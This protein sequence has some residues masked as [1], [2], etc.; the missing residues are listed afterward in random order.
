VSWPETWLRLR[1]RCLASE[2]FQ[3]WASRSALT[4][5]IARRRAGRLFDLC[6]GF[7]YSQIL[8]ASVETG[9]LEALR[10]GPLSTAELDRKLDL[11]PGRA[12]RLIDGSLALDLLQSRSGGRIGLGS[13][14]ATL[15]GNPAVLAMVRHHRLLYADLADPVALLR[16][17]MPCTALQDYWAYAQHEA[18]LQLEATRTDDYSAL[19]AASQ[20]LIATQVLDAYPLHRHRSLL[21]VGGGLGA[22]A[23]E[24][25]RRTPHLQCGVF[26]LP[27][28]AARAQ[29]RFDA[30]GMAGRIRA[31]GGNFLADPLP[32]GSDVISLVRVLHDHD[33]AAVR[34]VLQAIR[35][36]LA[37]GGRLLIAEPMP[38]GGATR[39]V[40]DAYFGFYLLAM[41]QGQARSPGRLAA[42]LA[43]SGFRPP[44]QRPT[45]IPL[46]C[47][48]LVTAPDC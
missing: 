47:Q 31:I 13:V 10:D 26:D 32:V 17:K 34:R 20:S 28:V 30:G 39:R 8:L 40:G 21:D 14:G 7:V 19:M 23:L 12:Q 4:S 37:P 33:D 15:L 2:R 46:Q 44:R 9:L 1:D 3:A 6:A 11:A 42:L 48:V 25:L 16:D 27:A 29:A 22:F 38:D 36:A 18:P 43:E 24:A 5:G 41:G 35:E 45:R